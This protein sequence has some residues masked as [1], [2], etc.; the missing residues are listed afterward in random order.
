MNTQQVPSV[1]HGSSILTPILH[2]RLNPAA[3]VQKEKAAYQLNQT[4]PGRHLVRLENYPAYHNTSS[5]SPP[6]EW[7]I[8]R[9]SV[10][11]TGRG[12]IIIHLGSWHL[13]GV[14]ST[15][16]H[17]GQSYRSAI[18]G[19]IQVYIHPGAEER[20]PT[21]DPRAVP[22]CLPARLRT[23]GRGGRVASLRRALVGRPPSR[24]QLA[25]PTWPSQLICWTVPGAK[26]APCGPILGGKSV[27]PMCHPST[28]ST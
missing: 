7:R 16:L 20:A 24:H 8:E 17:D 28:L 25:L 27:L 2:L 21:S 6:C 15:K 26:P 5:P 12:G 18:R 1:P 4:T 23:P 10:G 19:E 9:E 13:E 11:R 14:G 22:S 3:P